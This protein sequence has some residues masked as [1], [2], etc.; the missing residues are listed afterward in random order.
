M[1]YDAIED[2]FLDRLVAM[3]DF[4]FVVQAMPDTKDELERPATR[5]R[6][7]VAFGASRYGDKTS[8]GRPEILSLGIPTGEEFIELA[9]VVESNKKRG[10]AGLYQGL[11]LSRRLLHGWKPGHGLHRVASMTVDPVGYKDGFY[12]YTYLVLTSIIRVPLI[13]EQGLSFGPT[14]LPADAPP[15]LTKLTESTIAT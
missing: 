6:V 3:R 15:G 14:T 8:P 7:T 5:S 11:E 2:L 9:V 12:T 10:Q 13:N 1:T 4:G